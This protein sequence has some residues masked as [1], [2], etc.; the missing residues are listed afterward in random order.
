MM[1]STG[2]AQLRKIDAAESIYTS[3]CRLAAETPNGGYR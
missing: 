3:S 2:Y 1:S